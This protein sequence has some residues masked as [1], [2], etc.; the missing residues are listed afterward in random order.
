MYPPQRKAKSCTKIYQCDLCNYSTNQNGNLKKHKIKHHG[1][2][3]ALPSHSRHFEYVC[4]ICDKEFKLSTSLEN[5]L[6]IHNEIR[7]YH[8][9][10]CKASFRKPN[11]LR[12]HIDGVHLRLRPN[13]CNQCDAAYLMS[14]DLKRHMIQKHTS[15]R[16]FQCYYCQK[17]FMLVQYLKSHIN[18]VHVT[19]KKYELVKRH[20]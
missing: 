1:E 15:D 18:R 13:K 3:T 5:H 17:T 19:E 10:Q 20:E 8:C 12:I 7:N 4:H 2:P 9:T 6:N 16:P 11:Y 14:N